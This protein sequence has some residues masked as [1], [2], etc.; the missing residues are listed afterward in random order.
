MLLILTPADL[1][2]RGT[3]SRRPRTTSCSRNRP[4]ARAAIRGVTCVW[5]WFSG[6]STAI[7]GLATLA[8]RRDGRRQT[9]A[10]NPGRGRRGRGA[11]IGFLA[12]VEGARISWRRG[13]LRRVRAVVS[14]RVSSAAS[15]VGVC[16]HTEV[17]LMLYDEHKLC[18]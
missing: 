5:C 9:R 1:R 16:H 18:P 8:G 6:R 14:S 15:I 10:R 4:V 13:A 17:S 7:S 11:P 12:P 3:G 2:E